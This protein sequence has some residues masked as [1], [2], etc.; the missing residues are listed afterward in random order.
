M[1]P[2]LLKLCGC[3]RDPGIEEDDGLQ[4][5]VPPKVVP[6]DGAA[7]RSRDSSVVQ[8]PDQNAGN[9]ISTGSQAGIVD[10]SP[11]IPNPSTT[12]NALTK[13]PTI[14]IA[15]RLWGQA[16]DNLR[17]NKEPKLVQEYEKILSH[18][19]NEEESGT[20]SPN[21]VENTIETDNPEKR[22]LQMGRVIGAGL[23]K[24]QSARPM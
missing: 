7:K 22:R 19:L 2:F 3:K 8:P 10:Q 23:K 9:G 4:P 5:D 20:A 17:D 12:S 1:P 18:L 6:S 13:E 16:Y 15:E 24:R 21:E 11:T 14:T